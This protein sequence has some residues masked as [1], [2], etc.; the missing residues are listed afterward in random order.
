MPEAPI[1]AAGNGDAGASRPVALSLRGVEMRFGPTRVLHGID[2]DIRDGEFVTL[3]GPSGSGKT[4]ILRLIAGL[5]APTAGAILF[6]DRDIAPVPIFKRPFNTV[7]QD[8]ALFPHMTVARNVGYGLMVRGTPKAEIQ[9]RVAEVL[10]TVGLDQLAGRHPGQLSGG[11]KQRVAL[12]RAIVCEPR[13]ILLDEPLAAL[14]AELRR[15]MQ[16]FLKHLQR[17]IATT[18]LFVTHDQEEA[19]TM[20]D[21][22]VVM[23][24]GKVEQIGTPR[25]VYYYPQ[26]EFVAGFFGNNNLI[27]GQSDGSAVLTPLG[28]LPVAKGGCTGQVYAAIRPEAIQLLPPEAR[29]DVILDAIVEEVVFVGPT[30]HLLVRGP[31][32]ETPA[33]RVKMTS[34]K[35]EAIPHVGAP[36]RIG[37][38]TADIAVVPRSGP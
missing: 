4:T 35:D 11:Q 36:V 7:F 33:L 38:N 24:N 5:M 27:A 14:D 6:E 29:P 37:W 8:Y 3:L 20:S 32:N 2:L 17:R 12:A 28:L 23:N 16:L 22:V 18:F 34:T 26:T 25:D 9:R 30:S 19:I 13:L 15:Q 1:G 21:R 10:D 31:D